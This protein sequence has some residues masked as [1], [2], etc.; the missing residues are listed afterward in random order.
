MPVPTDLDQI[1][2][3]LKVLGRRELFSLLKLRNKYQAQLEA[4][5]KKLKAQEQGKIVEP[6][7]NDEQKEEEVD[8]ELEETIK[9]VERERKRADKKERERKLKSDMRLKM[10]VIANTDIHN[11]NDDLLFDRRTLERL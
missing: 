7:L 10:S 8:K 11:G 3:D 5:R 9:R 4:E 1:C 6:E 2:S